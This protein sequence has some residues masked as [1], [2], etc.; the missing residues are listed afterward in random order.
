MNLP[1]NI[2]HALDEKWSRG[3]TEIPAGK[4]ALVCTT[5]WQ[6]CATTHLEFK[7]RHIIRPSITAPARPDK[8]KS[9]AV[10]WAGDPSDGALAFLVAVVN[11]VR[12]R[13]SVDEF[14]LVARPTSP[15]GPEV[16]DYLSDSD[17]VRVGSDDLDEVL[18]T[19]KIYAAPS[20]S[21]ISF[22][23]NA[24]RA[25]CAGALVVAPA[26]YGYPECFS[27]TASMLCV[28]SYDNAMYAM[29]FAANLVEALEFDTWHHVDSFVENAR[30][31]FSVDKEKFAWEEFLGFLE[32]VS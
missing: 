11:G 6:D 14:K 3:E 21:P 28:H 15:V 20:F 16:W 9:R 26:K 19:S 4:T 22:D 29:S 13:A 17:D 18:S 31:N 1:D 5:S 7:R 24:A 12:R 23:A 27:A 10:C 25:S 8:I 30:S 32:V 2:L